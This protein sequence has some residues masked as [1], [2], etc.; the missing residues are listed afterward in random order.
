MSELFVV[1]KNE[2]D[3]I[4]T[5]TMSSGIP[6]VNDAVYFVPEF[7]D[8]PRKPVAHVV[9]AIIWFPPEEYTV[10]LTKYNRAVDV[11]IVLKKLKV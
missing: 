6:R 3:E 10:P 5:R 2:K 9:S 1:F 4:Q 11:L 7:L 8:T